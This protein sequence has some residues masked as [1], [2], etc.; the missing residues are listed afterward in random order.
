MTPVRWR[1][2]VAV[3][4]FLG[5]AASGADAQADAKHAEGSRGMAATGSVF[6]TRAAV[7]ALEAGGNAIDAAAAAAFAIMVTDPANTSV[8]GR[9]QILI[10][11]ASGELIAIDGAT[12]APAGVPPLAGAN[13]DRTGFKTAAI[14]GAPAALAR[15]VARYGRR[16]LGQALAPAIA[17]AEDGFPVPARLAAAF[18]RTRTALAAT[19]GAARH[20]LKPDGSAYREG[21]RFR[22]PA[23][24]AL[25]RRL[26]ADGVEALYHGTV[27]EAIAA[28]MRA[29]GGFVTAADLAAY[30]VQDGV[31]VRTPYRGYDVASAGGRAW[32]NTLTEMLNILGNFPPPRGEP[33]PAGAELLAR[34]VAQSLEDRPQQLG[35][36]KPKLDGFP[37]DTLSSAPFAAD[38]ANRIRAALGRGPAAAEGGSGD[39]DTSHLSVMD[40]EGNAVALTM[41]IGPTFGTRI[42][43]AES[44]FLFGYSYRMRSDPTPNARDLTEMTPTIVSSGGRPVLVIGGAGSERIPSAIL[45]VMSNVIDRGWSLPR[46]MTA[47]RLSAAGAVIR[48]QPGFRPD[49]ATALAAQGFRIETIA[50][51]D[52]RHAGL[53]HAVARD[54]ATGRFLGAADAGDSGSAGGPGARPAAPPA[55]DR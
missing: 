9:A 1:A 38:R 55:R 48:L 21:E 43:S 26:A 33:D 46:A 29:G 15:M 53:V 28:E 30:R 37:L 5:A 22:Q 36:L 39:H 49:V 45:Q 13:D 2:P 10:R 54:P 40:A 24:A 47:P 18:A 51:D 35:T 20:F 27:A 23:L 25:L 42:A 16:T 4:L 32:G 50:P 44:G 7:S 34:I 3:A 12:E 31:V 52:P 17:L 11:L 6:A 19:P 14:P 41:S 8:G